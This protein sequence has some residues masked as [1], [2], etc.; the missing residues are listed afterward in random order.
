MSEEVQWHLLQGLAGAP[1][2]E[3]SASSNE[4]A[5]PLPPLAQPVPI[6]PVPMRD[7]PMTLLNDPTI[8]STP[9]ATPKMRSRAGSQDSA[10]SQ[11]SLGD[12]GKGKVPE[13]IHI[14]LTKCAAL[15]C[16]Y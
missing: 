11:S 8:A 7:I 2:A 3:S 6:A 5:P 14:S 1:V 16:I 9:A 4:T 10:S 15:S 13:Q 12:L